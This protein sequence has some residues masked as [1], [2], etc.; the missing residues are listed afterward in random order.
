[1]TENEYQT[2]R[3]I[4]VKGCLSEKRDFIETMTARTLGDFIDRHEFDFADPSQCESW[5]YMA[6]IHA[7]KCE[8]YIFAVDGPATCADPCNSSCECVPCQT[9]PEVVYPDG[10][11]HEYDKGELD[12]YWPNEKAPSA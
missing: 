3:R 9:S 10:S 5:K 2:L 12:T 4:F 7:I 8:S 1:M 11:P 6:K